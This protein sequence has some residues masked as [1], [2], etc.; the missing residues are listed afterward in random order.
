M[1]LVQLHTET[2]TVW[3][4]TYT[5]V[6]PAYHTLQILPTTNIYKHTFAAFLLSFTGS[7]QPCRMTA[8]L[9]HT[10]PV[11]KSSI[12][13]QFTDVHDCFTHVTLHCRRKPISERKVAI[14]LYGFPP[15]VGATGTAALLNVPRSLQA[16]LGAMKVRPKALLGMTLHA[17]C[18]TLLILRLH[19]G[20]NADVMS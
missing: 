4:C 17:M 13:L 3:R 7:S 11:R 10:Y 5:T 1:L 19:L 12:K 16:L 18:G 8:T 15:G 2:L 9:R 20:P 6:T 14:L